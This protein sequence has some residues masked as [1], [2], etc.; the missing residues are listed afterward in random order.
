MTDR[1][2]HRE[3]VPILIDEPAPA[4]TNGE[5]ADRS[6]APGGVLA[7]ERLD[8]VRPHEHEGDEADDAE[9]LEPSAPPQPAPRWSGAGKRIFARPIA[10]ADRPWD[11]ERVVKVVATVLTL[12]VTTLVMMRAAQ[13]WPFKPSTDLIFDDNTPNGGDMGA[14]V[15]GP[16]YLRDTLL[17]SG[18]LNGWSMDWY[19]GMPAYRFYMVLPALAIVA[20]DSVLAYG[21]AFK[22]VAV[23][24]LITFPL[25]CWAFGRLARFRYPL[26]ELFAFAGLI[27]AL[28]ESF[29]IYGGNLKSTMAG[30]FS[31]SIAMTLTMLGLGLLARGLETGKYRVW[32][33]VI[34]AAACV[35]HGIVAIYVAVAATVF[36]MLWVDRKRIWYILSVG[37]TT[38][39]LAAWWVG[40]FLSNHDFMTDMKYEARPSGAED[41]YWD[42]FFP[43]VTTIDVLVTT[44]AV[45]GLVASIARR[46]L[47]GVAMGVVSF[48]FVAFVYVARDSLPFI[49][50]LW[51]PRLLPWFY[52]MRYLLMAVGVAEIAV[53]AVNLV[54]NRPNTSWGSWSTGTATLAGGGL[55]ALLVLGFM[56]EL[57]PGGSKVTKHGESVY[58]WGPF[59]K[60]GPDYD[61]QGDGW[62]RYNFKGYENKE[63]YPEYQHLV[64]T[65][66][67]LG[68]QRGCGRAYWEHSETNGS[69]GSPM[70]L[71]LLP[72]WTDSCIGSMEG[73]F[74]EASGTTPYHF[75][76]TASMSENSSQPVRALRYS[77]L[78]AAAGVP[79]LQSLGV[80]YVM[81]LTDAAK[82]EAA[83][84]DD[85][86]E[87]ARSGPWT[88]YELNDSPVVAALDVQPVVVEPRGGDQRERNLELGTS[89]FQHRDEWAAMPADGGPAEWQRITVEVD[90]ARRQ[91]DDANESDQVDVVQPAQAIE[92][93]VL[94]P[95]SVSDV[96]MGD[97]SLSFRVDKPGVPVLVKV[98]YFP[99]WTA[100]GAEGPYRIGP[101]MMVVVPTDNEVTLEYAGSKTDSIF[102]VMTLLG[103]VLCIVWRRRGDVSVDPPVWAAAGVDAQTLPP[104]R[105]DGEA[106]GPPPPPFLAN[107]EVHGEMDEFRSQ[108]VDERLDGPPDERLDERLDEPRSDD[109]DAPPGPFR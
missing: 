70:A 46:N 99:N 98:S 78:D 86:V 25:A 66:D 75:L 22:V 64:D 65:M 101:N 2:D 37:V 55:A 81:L 18:Q 76:A 32:A 58:A 56:F 38:V 107:A 69:Y 41:S 13:F 53:L 23:S 72:F 28:D 94:D 61:A 85:L 48:I 59:A 71:M 33:S 9:Y 90:Q 42:M 80:R 49:G 5:R 47:T 79:Q 21:I 15:W 11:T 51:N 19:A 16:A 68:E 108:Q 8:P 109:P 104:P 54:R 45:I 29:S 35:S 102:Y 67:G 44:L 39:L 14:H 12:I 87:V 34:L 82:A 103:V 77:G 50:L 89:W 27:F 62:S 1:I 6:E 84:N 17:P 4:I 60:A 95:V 83:T 31:F 20:L 52:L 74:F 57:L 97:Q 43:Q 10:W 30:E 24:G 40:P 93:V 88:I 106:D 73:L 96:R 100:E 3:D 26:P 105:S 63:A 91:G 7:P 36:A 92:Q